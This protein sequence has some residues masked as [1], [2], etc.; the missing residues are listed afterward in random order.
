MTQE[1]GLSDSV[2]RVLNKIG[3]VS[4]GPSH[5]KSFLHAFFGK[6]SSVHEHVSSLVNGASP[7]E[8]LFDRVVRPMSDPVSEKT[9]PS[10]VIRAGSWKSFRCK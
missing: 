10:G 2:R 6:V 5:G 7:L 1:G 3:S 8:D 4:P 9:N